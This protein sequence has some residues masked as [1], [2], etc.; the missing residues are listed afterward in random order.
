MSNARKWFTEPSNRSMPRSPSDF[1][2][3][4]IPQYS[5]ES[6]AKT[7]ST[8]P[9]NVHYHIIKIGDLGNV[10][11]SLFEVLKNKY[12]ITTTEA[13]DIF[14]NYLGAACPEC[15]SGLTGELLQTIESSKSMRGSVF[16]D[17]S[18]DIQCILNGTCAYCNSKEYYIIWFG[19]K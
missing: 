5:L 11:R 18:S 4:D 10:T 2:L 9:Y 8:D 16:L 14:N 1:N 15:L 3:F 13:V 17:N 19:E 7:I 12:T 6:W